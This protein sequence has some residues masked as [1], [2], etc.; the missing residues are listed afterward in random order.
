MRIDSETSVLKPT[1]YAVCLFLFMFQPELT[2][3]DGKPFT[4]HH[5]R[6]GQRLL[7]QV[8]TETKSGYDPN[9]SIGCAI[10]GGKKS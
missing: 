7:G 1:V 2:L 9:F 3:W 5:S 6:S 10:S 4:G 8:R